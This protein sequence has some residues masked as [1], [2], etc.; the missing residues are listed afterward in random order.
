MFASW[1]WKC[2]TPVELLGVWLPPSPAAEWLN[3]RRRQRQLNRAEAA[4]SQ[5]VLLVEP[6][7]TIEMRL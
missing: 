4:T 7:K 5:N 6:E 1:E 3:Y 2:N